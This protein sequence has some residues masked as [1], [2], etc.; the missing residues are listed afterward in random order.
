MELREEEKGQGG[1]SLSELSRVDAGA[2]WGPSAS[3]PKAAAK[4]TGAR[5]HGADRAAAS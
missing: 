1:L 4:G 3:G 2:C 5:Q